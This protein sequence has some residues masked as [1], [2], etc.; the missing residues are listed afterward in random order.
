M[1]SGEDMLKSVLVAAMRCGSS[2]GNDSPLCISAERHLS[3]KGEARNSTSGNSIWVY[4]F[5]KNDA[6]PALDSLL[7]D[8]SQSEAEFM[9]FAK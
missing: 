8:V 4:L 5:W 1:K 6:G 7:T 3:R 2:H 9:L